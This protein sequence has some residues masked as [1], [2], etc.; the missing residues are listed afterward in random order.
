MT[1]DEKQA[2]TDYIL[3]PSFSLYC[4]GSKKRNAERGKLCETCVSLRLSARHRELLKI[5][6][7]LL[8][9]NHRCIKL[10]KFK[11]SWKRI[12]TMH[13]VFKLRSRTPGIWCSK[14]RL[15]TLLTLINKHLD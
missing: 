6:Q 9:E 4:H 13:V 12:K 7:T 10:L 8:Q 1:S 5:L 2:A 14:T 15:E 11:Q 3:M